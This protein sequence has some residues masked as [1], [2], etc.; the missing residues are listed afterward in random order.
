MKPNVVDWRIT[1]NCNQAC[2]YCYATDYAM[3]VVTQPKYDKLIISKIAELGNESVCIS[4]GEPLLD[5]NGERA[6]RIIKELKDRGVNIFLSTNGTNYMDLERKYNIGALLSKLSLPLDGYDIESSG[7]NGR[8]NSFIFVK[9]IL[10]EYNNNF[11]N[12]KTIPNIKVSTVVT[13]RNIKEYEYWEKL[14]S[15]ISKYPIIRLWKI[16]DFIPE[17]RGEKN[18]DNLSYDSKDFDV[19]TAFITNHKNTLSCPIEIINRDSRSQIYFIIRPDGSV[20]IPQDSNDVTKEIVIG[21]IINDS[22]DFL[23]REWGKHADSAKCSIYS[24]GRAIEDIR[25]VSEDDISKFILTKISGDKLFSVQQ[26]LNRVVSDKSVSIAIAESRFNALKSGLTPV[27][28][29][30][31]PIINLPEL[32]LQVYLIN[33]LFNA[34]AGYTA[35][36]IA[37][38]I[39]RNGAIGWCA[40]YKLIGAKEKSTSEDMGSPKIVFRIALFASNMQECTNELN[41]IIDKIREAYV[42][43]S[44]DYVP[45]KYVAYDRILNTDEN[46]GLDGRLIKY[47]EPQKLLHLSRQEKEVLTAMSSFCNSNNLSQASLLNLLIN[48][49]NWKKRNANNLLLR[50]IDFLRTK[51][52]I[53]MFQLVTNDDQLGFITFLIIYD[54]HPMYSEREEDL[55][56]QFED[57]VKKLPGVTHI[58]LLNNG[59]WDADVEIKVK[60]RGE[61]S[62]IVS[63]I[64]K[65]FGSEIRHIQYME[66]V[67]EYRFTFLIPVVIKKIESMKG[68]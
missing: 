34:N 27:I 15:F 1:S 3:P 29:E 48:K 32:G 57:Y 47:L 2:E 65:R 7:I 10:D 49:F 36:Q 13:K 56:L 39:C 43:K 40:Q 53:N 4:G 63:M 42:S 8:G 38:E 58:N 22:V 6:Y 20:V 9:E 66:L 19:F 55:K 33:L 44:I 51:Q 45:E 59:D 52:I 61:L 23:L 14:S 64:L 46:G 12:G 41:S 50:N 28:R 25:R 5:D 16:Y 54:L 21:N 18:K 67:R 60:T 26:L 30:I 17:N 31:V 68:N 37:N 24:L 62:Q 11:H 35:E